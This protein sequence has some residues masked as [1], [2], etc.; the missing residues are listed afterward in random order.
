MTSRKPR[1]RPDGPFCLGPISALP[2]EGSQPQEDE[3][4]HGV[5]GGGRV[6][7]HVLRPG[8]QPLMVQCGIEE[9]AV[10]IGKTIQDLIGQPARRHEPALL[11]PG[12]V[13]GE[14]PVCEQRVVLEHALAARAAILPRPSELAGRGL[15]AQGDRRGGGRRRLEI[16]LRRRAI[17]VVT[18]QV[19]QPRAGRQCPNREAVPGGQRLVI[20][21]RLCADPTSGEERR[22][23]FGQPRSNGCFREAVLLGHLTVR[24]DA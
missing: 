12:F 4:S 17:V 1:H 24:P 6:V 23:S 3:G 16:A 9:P 14:E 19:E 11:V 2:G 8:D 13:Q 21:G 18:E 10:R 5:S 15:Q 7:L 20:T 22:P